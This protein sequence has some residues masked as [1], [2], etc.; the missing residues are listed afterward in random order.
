MPYKVGELVMQ[1]GGDQP[2]KVQKIGADEQ[3]IRMVTCTWFVDGAQLEALFLPGQL[4]YYRP[5]LPDVAN[6]PLGS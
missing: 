4:R 3:G 1:R 2:M 6:P 5:E